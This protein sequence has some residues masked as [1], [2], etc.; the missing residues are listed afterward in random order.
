MAAALAPCRSIRRWSVR[1]PRSTRKQSSGPG[2]AP[3]AFCRNR[4]R[5]ATA[6]SEVTADAQDR[7]R[8]ARPGTWSP[9]GRRCPRRVGRGCWMAG[10]ANVLSTTT[11]GRR[12]P[13]ASRRRHRGR[14]RGD[15]DDLEVR[16]RRR[17]EPDQPGPLGER[18]P[19][20]V[21]AGR[22]VDVA[23][24]DA[25]PAPDPLEIAVRPAVDVVPDDDLLAR[26]G[27]LG[28]RGGRRRARRERRSRRVPPSRA[29]TARSSRS[30]VG[31]CE[32]AYS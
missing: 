31:F 16:V 8:V 2:T 32:R 22:Q 3:I 17:L 21:R 18:L 19:Q 5:S 28:D 20:D 14:G 13:S 27:Q 15:V 4:S 10:E 9:S 29:A 1:S 6:A 12:P 23:G 26:A 24:V 7:V 30:R 25:G 11:S